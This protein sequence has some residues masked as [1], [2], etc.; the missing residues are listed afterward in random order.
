MYPMFQYTH[1]NFFSWIITKFTD[2]P[3]FLGHHRRADKTLRDLILSVK[4][5]GPLVTAETNHKKLIPLKLTGK[6]EYL[7]ESNFIR[8]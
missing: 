5:L 6:L 8:T 3:S 4:Y 2:P 1:Y 7:Y